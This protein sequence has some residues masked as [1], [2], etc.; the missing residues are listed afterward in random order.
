MKSLYNLDED[1]TQGAIAINLLPLVSQS[2]PGRV[3]DE[4]SNSRKRY[5]D[6]YLAVI[7]QLKELYFLLMQYTVPNPGCLSAW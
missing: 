1:E 6:T 7:L 4:M 2:E 5:F 3:A